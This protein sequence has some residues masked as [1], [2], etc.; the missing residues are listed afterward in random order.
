MIDQ[1]V[2]LYL[3]N[4]QG[5]RELAITNL[6][7]PNFKNVLAC[8]IYILIRLIYTINKNYIDQINDTVVSM[9]STKKV[10][11]AD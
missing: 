6:D 9:S 8:F 10:N 3:R 4:N 2:F 5:D 1:T 7:K 11:F